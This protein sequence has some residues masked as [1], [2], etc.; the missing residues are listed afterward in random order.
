MDRIV[1]LL[2]L[3]VCGSTILA[4]T[5]GTFTATGNMTTP[6]ALHS[7]TLLPNGKVL[8][9]QGTYSLG[10]FSSSAAELYDPATRTFTATGG[11]ATVSGIGTLLGNG[12]VLITGNTAQLYDPAIDTFAPTG[13]YVGPFFYSPFFYPDTAT[14]LPDGRVLIVGSACGDCWLEHEELYDPVT[15]TFKVAGKLHTIDSGSDIGE[16]STA[17]LLP[18]GKVLVAGGAGYFSDFSVAELYDP[19]T[20]AF[21]ATGNMTVARAGHTATLL[22][23]GTVLIAGGV[24]FGGSASAEVYNPAT[25]TFSSTGNMTTPRNAHTATLLPDGTVLLAGG[26]SYAASASADVYNPGTGM[27]SATGNMATPR[28]WQAASLLPDGT[29][30]MTGGGSNAAVAMASAELYTP[31]SLVPV[32]VPM[33]L[34]LS[35]DGQGQGAIQHA[36]T[37]RIASASDPAVAGEYLSIYLTGLA[38]GSV[39]PPQ[40]AIGGRLAEVTF[41]GD[42][43]GYPGQNVVNVQMPSGVAP[44][45]A[46]PVRLTSLGRP[47]NEV[48]MG[49]A[50]D[51]ALQQAVTA[52]KTAA[53]TDSLNFWQW[54]WYWQYLPGVS[55]TPAGFGVVGSISPDVME[56]IITA[57]GGDPLQNVS[58]EQWVVYFRQVTP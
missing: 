3:G 28:F 14:L 26:Q 17:T 15:G 57:G 29:V 31:L 48:T 1:F 42:V 18:N 39:I 33:L 34:A 9:T 19:S 21:T 5:P 35:G 20:D 8:I 11:T 45:P 38:D 43:P 54:A 7:A 49:V 44:G 55:G 10:Q 32:P 56:Q 58:A 47:S 40:V 53:G 51:A 41:F 37:T 46:V 4:Q 2:G 23:D 50:L 36:G 25:G 52:M 22:P 12:K 27:F 6:R 24:P 16:S 30:L 13:S